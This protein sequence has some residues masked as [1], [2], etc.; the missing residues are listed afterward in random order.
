MNCLP[1][2]VHHSPFTKNKRALPLLYGMGHGASSIEFKNKKAPTPLETEKWSSVNVPADYR[3]SG[4]G[5]GHPVVYQSQPTVLQG[6]CQGC[7]GIEHRERSRRSEVR[8]QRT[9][10]SRQQ[11]AGSIKMEDRGRRRCCQLSVVRGPLQGRLGFESDLLSRFIGWGHKLLYGF[12]NNLN[13]LI[14]FAQP[15][16]QFSE[17]AG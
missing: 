14:M 9:K 12:K 17:L 1:I 4:Y 3:L 13:L 11:I 7:N 2:T 15:L 16:F 5:E 6:M 10:D 8:D